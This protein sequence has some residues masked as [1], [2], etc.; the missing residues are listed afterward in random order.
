MQTCP[1]NCTHVHVEVSWP[2]Y[3][4]AHKH[5]HKISFSLLFSHHVYCQKS[6]LTAHIY[7]ATKKKKNLKSHFILLAKSIPSSANTHVKTKYTRQC[8]CIFMNT[9]T[10][11]M[12]A[13]KIFVEI[14]FFFSIFHP[15]V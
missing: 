15:S 10:Y 3:V 4:P 5:M 6:D 9:F 13:K 11:Y 2:G 12:I 14:N 8:N 7:T 1:T